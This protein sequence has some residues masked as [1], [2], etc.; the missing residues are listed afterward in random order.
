MK[1]QAFVSAWYKGDT[2]ARAFTDLT[3]EGLDGRPAIDITPEDG[4]NA[5]VI[6]P[7]PVD[8][9]AW[10]SPG[11]RATTGWQEAYKYPD[12]YT[13]WKKI[14]ITA[15]YP[16][17]QHLKVVYIRD[18]DGGTGDYVDVGSLSPDALLDFQNTFSVSR[19]MTVREDRL[20]TWMMAPRTV[21]GLNMTGTN[22]TDL[23]LLT[24][25]EGGPAK[26]TCQRNDYDRAVEYA[27][28]LASRYFSEGAAYTIETPFDAGLAF[29]PGQRIATLT[30]KQPTGTDSKAKTTNASIQSVSVDVLRG[31]VSITTAAPVHPIYF[32]NQ[33]SMSP[34]FGG[35]ISPSLGGTISQAVQK[36]QTQVA[37]LPTTGSGGGAPGS[38]A[39]DENVVVDW[40][41]ASSTFAIG[42]A[43]VF[44][45]GA[46]TLANPASLPAVPDFGI[47]IAVGADG[48]SARIVKWGVFYLPTSGSGVTVADNSV[49]YLDGTTPGAIST[50]KTDNLLFKSAKNGECFIATA[51]GAAAVPPT[52]TVTLTGNYSTFTVGKIL[53][54]NGSSWALADIANITSDDMIVG[55]VTANSSTET[56]ICTWGVCTI[57][58]L[59]NNS[60]YYLSES[61]PGTATLTNGSF[62][63]FKVANNQV[64]IERNMPVIG[65]TTNGG[66][67]LTIYT[68]PSKKM[69][70]LQTAQLQANRSGTVFDYTHVNVIT[71]TTTAPSG[72]GVKGQMHMIY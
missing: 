62:P 13:S 6:R 55:V 66:G 37:N 10:T 58:G 14:V 4:T 26:W 1:P 33:G 7:S 20:Q 30:F 59:T 39:V 68:D 19:K 36:L 64:F 57:A 25:D 61:T 67:R 53:L 2:G 27:K 54:Y 56:K 44:N 38:K 23:K 28:R 48:G 18:Y 9:F 49:Y 65:D 69:Q 52:V 70:M 42:S 15:A 50:T 17:A 8:M 40:T 35:P 34:S 16:S 45:A 41:G 3:K 46:W 63:V 24:S 12:Y 32:S 43:V 21:V 5:I 72:A 71:T 51:A 29:S 60:T 22:P 11:V 31:R 47:V